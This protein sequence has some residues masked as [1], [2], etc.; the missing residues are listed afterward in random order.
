MAFLHPFSRGTKHLIPRSSSAPRGNQT[1]LPVLLESLRNEI[2]RT[3]STRRCADDLL[4]SSAFLPISELLYRIEVV[5]LDVS[6]DPM[7][8]DMA[9]ARRK[10]ARGR[11]R[12]GVLSD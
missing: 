11:A 10:Y 9:D 3:I 5:V 7:R 2:R 8:T 1:Y 12:E 6:Q 4:R